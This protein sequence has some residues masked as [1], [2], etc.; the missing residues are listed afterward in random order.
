MKK[1]KRELKYTLSGQMTA[2]FGGL[3]GVVRRVVFSGNTGVLG[4]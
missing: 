1:A 3:L 2:I 4:R